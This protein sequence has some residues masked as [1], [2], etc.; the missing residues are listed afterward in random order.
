M[1]RLET[2]SYSKWGDLFHALFFQVEN[3][4]KIP[5]FLACSIGLDPETSS[6]SFIS[7]VIS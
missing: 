5:K 6:S 4:S 1:L 7:I 3:I 2:R